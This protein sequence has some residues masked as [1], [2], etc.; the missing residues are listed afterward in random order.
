MYAMEGGGGLMYVFNFIIC[1]QSRG[2]FMPTC[3]Y[4]HKFSVTISNM[5]YH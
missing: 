1:S 3:S 4:H 2:M 5:I